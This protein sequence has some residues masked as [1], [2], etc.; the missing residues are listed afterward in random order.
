MTSPRRT[1]I[2]LARRSSASGSARS[3]VV[4]NGEHN[5]HRGA[6]AALGARDRL[7]VH[8]HRALCLEHDVPEATSAR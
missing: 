7:G 1:L 4:I 8:R 6:Y 5:I 3:L 2:G